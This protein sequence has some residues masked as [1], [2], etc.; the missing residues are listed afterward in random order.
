MSATGGQ[1]PRHV[2]LLIA[3]RMPDRSVRQLVI[4]AD[5]RFNEG[6]LRLMKQAA[7]DVVESYVCEPDD[8]E[9]SAWSLETWTREALSVAHRVFGFRERIYDRDTSPSPLEDRS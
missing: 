1:L 3:I 9:A 6:D 5:P 2:E 4:E 8:M 7:L